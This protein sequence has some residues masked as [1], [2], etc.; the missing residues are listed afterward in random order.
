MSKPWMCKNC[1]QPMRGHG[2]SKMCAEIQRLREE[3]GRL[4]RALVNIANKTEDGATAAYAC[5]QA[6]SE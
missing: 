6:A 3:V 4:R 2:T 1:K 5:E